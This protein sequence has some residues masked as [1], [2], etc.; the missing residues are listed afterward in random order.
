MT[1]EIPQDQWVPYFNDVSRLYQGWS[2]TIEVLAG[3]LG[4]QREAEDVPFQGMS[5]E[6]KGSECGDV[7]VEIGDA[8]TSYE[9]HH[10]DHP[11][12]VRGAELQLGAETDIEIESEDGIVTIVRLRRRR[13]LPEERS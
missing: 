7:L 5:L 11:M 13:E 4:D 3:T 2:T 10:V 12:I 9:V 6:T 1:H 8:G